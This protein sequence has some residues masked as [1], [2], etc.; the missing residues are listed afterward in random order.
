M[1]YC[2]MCGQEMDIE[3]RFCGECGAQ[4]RRRSQPVPVESDSHTITTSPQG[5]IATASTSM[6]GGT[7]E[8]GL[9]RRLFSTQGRIGRK[10]FWFFQLVAIAFLIG[11]GVIGSEFETSNGSDAGGI[12]MLIAIAVLFLPSWGVSIRRA[13]DLNRSD[14]FA[15]L[16]IV[17]L[18]GWVV[19]LMLGFQGG[20]SGPNDYGMPNSGTI[21]RKN[22]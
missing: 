10:G 3:S 20:T 15:I 18:I 2:T 17:P 6:A 1:P 11:A 22:V 8:R 14:G 7:D 12:A 21:L 13:H 19:L 5:A 16:S 4:I 9:I